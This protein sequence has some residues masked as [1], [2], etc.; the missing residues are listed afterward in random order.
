M[1]TALL[2]AS[3]FAFGD[4]LNL[5]HKSAAVPALAG[6]TVMVIGMSFGYNTGCE[7]IWVS[8]WS[9]RDR[10]PTCRAT[11]YGLAKQRAPRPFPPHLAPWLVTA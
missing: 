1:S 9:A 4:R 11:D 10:C 6:M 7:C 5:Q 3:L 8:P 2:M